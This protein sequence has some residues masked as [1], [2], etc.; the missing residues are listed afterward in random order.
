MAIRDVSTLSIAELISL[1]G[2]SAVVTGGARGIGRA[3][4]HRGPVGLAHAREADDQRN[5]DQ[6]PCT[7]C[8]PPLVLGMRRERAEILKRQRIMNPAIAAIVRMDTRPMCRSRSLRR[9]HRRTA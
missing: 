2:R 1:S 6:T 5:P 4:A 8:Q 7:H 9:Y 3:I